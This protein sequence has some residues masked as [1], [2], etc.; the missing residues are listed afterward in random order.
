MQKAK[1]TAN[2]RIAVCAQ[3]FGFG[4]VSKACAIAKALIEGCQ[5]LELV[6]I[7]DSISKEFMKREGVWQESRDV[8]IG[9]DTVSNLN[10]QDFEGLDGAVVVLDPKMASF[11]VL[12]GI[13]VFF[14]NFHVYRIFIYILFRM[15]LVPVTNL[16]LKALKIF[17]L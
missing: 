11:W 1:K 7:A 3:S 8:T 17:T 15:F 12:C 14:N 5:G 2:K 13:R 4:P 6:C 16:P 9:D 10:R